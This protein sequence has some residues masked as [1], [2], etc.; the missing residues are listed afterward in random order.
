MCQSDGP[1]RVAQATNW[2]PRCITSVKTVVGP[3]VRDLLDVREV[4]GLT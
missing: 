1:E 3:K 2:A 4:F